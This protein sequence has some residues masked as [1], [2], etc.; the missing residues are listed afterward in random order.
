[1][2]R[3]KRKNKNDIVIDLTSLLDIIFI[4]LLVVMLGQTSDFDQKHNELEE[5][6]AE[7]N[8]AKQLYED[9]VDSSDYIQKNTRSASISVPIDPDDFHRRTITL[10]AE[11]SET[12]S[13]I[14]EGNDVD[15]SLNAFK[16]SLE[17]YIE[18]HKDCLIIMLS[19]NDNDDKILYRDEKA[20]SSILSE[21]SEEHDNVYIKGNLGD[22]ET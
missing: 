1:M 16:E 3:N 4:F 8:D 5:S 22:I 14:L 9:M 7:A 19:L 11:G 18:T 10:L 21:L 15:D 2:S 12:E 6:L 13:F 20:V 17:I